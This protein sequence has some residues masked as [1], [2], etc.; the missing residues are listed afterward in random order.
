[1]NKHDHHDCAH[2]LKFCA[3]CNEAYCTKCDT[4]W[5]SEPC[6]MSHYPWIYSSPVTVTTPTITGPYWATTTWGGTDGGCGSSTDRYTA[7]D[8]IHAYTTSHVRG[9]N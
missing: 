8:D 1:M 9:R 7:N 5:A 2:A 6:T 3:P 4:V